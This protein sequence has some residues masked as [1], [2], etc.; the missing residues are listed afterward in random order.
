MF[1]SAIPWTQILSKCNLESPGYMEAVEATRKYH[2][3]K[4]AKDELERQK[5]EAKK[6]ASA[7][8]KKY[9]KKMNAG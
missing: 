2:E 5:K 1:N 6:L 7:R 3:E 8:R 4:R 9:Y